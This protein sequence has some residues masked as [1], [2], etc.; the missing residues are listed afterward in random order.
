MSILT[1]T[2]AGSRGRALVPIGVRLWR[3]V[4]KSAGD[5]ACWEWG[6]AKTPLG[7]GKIGK[8]GARGWHLTH[9]V[10]WIE[11]NGEIPDGLVIC[12]QCDNPACCNPRHLFQGTAADNVEDKVRKKR[13]LFGDRMSK[14]IRASEAFNAGIK[15]RAKLSEAQILRI[16]ARALAGEGQASIAKDYGV[17]QSHVSRIKTGS[18]W[19]QL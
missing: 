14:A 5:T 8:E 19:K 3:R 7:Y 6:G 9:R 4:D 13:H 11:A 10:A 16:R 2:A 1:K 12:H 15:E 18:V 17:T